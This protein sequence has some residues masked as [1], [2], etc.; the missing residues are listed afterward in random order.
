MMLQNF[1]I[2]NSLVL[3]AVASSMTNEIE[4]NTINKTLQRYFY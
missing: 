3:L 1:C 4:A 2:L